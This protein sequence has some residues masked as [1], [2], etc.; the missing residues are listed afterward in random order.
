M[1]VSVSYIDIGACVG[2]LYRS[3]ICVCARYLLR[4]FVSGA[5]HGSTYKGNCSQI[6][7]SFAGGCRT[8]VGY[9][10]QTVHRIGCFSRA[11]FVTT[12]WRF[13]FSKTHD[14]DHLYVRPLD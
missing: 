6:R 5:E 1:L 7:E 2:L 9:N 11:F 13:S 12:N 10:V 8:D 4:Y 14:T 3:S